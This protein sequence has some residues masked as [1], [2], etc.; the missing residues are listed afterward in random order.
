MCDRALTGIAAFDPAAAEL[1]AERRLEPALGGMGFCP[2][3]AG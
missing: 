3:W 2:Q 1:L